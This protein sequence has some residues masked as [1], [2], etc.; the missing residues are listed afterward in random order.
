MG[1][2]QKMQLASILECLTADKQLRVMYLKELLYDWSERMRE[3]KE[4][5]TEVGSQPL[6]AIAIAIRPFPR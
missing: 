2:L 3:A 6:R 5:W 1:P 4:N